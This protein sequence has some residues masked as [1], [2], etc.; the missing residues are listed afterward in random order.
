MANASLIMITK[1][2]PENYF[3]Y[4]KCETEVG[5]FDFYRGGVAIFDTRTHMSVEGVHE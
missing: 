2:F 4:T 3:K 5:L 1:C